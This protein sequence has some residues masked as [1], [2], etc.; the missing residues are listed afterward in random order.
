MVA[1]ARDSIPGFD[2]IGISTID[3]RGSVHTRASV[4]EVVDVL[5]SL[6]YGL[7]EGPCVD[8]VHGEDVVSAPTIRHDQR[9]PRYVPKAVAEG[10]RS[11]LA[12][13]L[14]LD[15]KGT[16]GSLNFYSTVSEDIDP[17]AASMAALFAEHAAIAFGY[18]SEI[19]GLNQALQTRKVIGQALG[20]LMERYQMSEDAA[21]SFLVRA[22]TTGNI[23]L[24]DI[25]QEL[26]DRNNAT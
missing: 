6:Q 16:V 12:V 25:A 4:G 11:Q 19:E 5:D 22:S 3:K 17:E 9:W 2:A 23:K 26:V 8:E 10:L 13:R 21:F 7:G 18:V 1:V 24:R 14:F 20:I 15:D